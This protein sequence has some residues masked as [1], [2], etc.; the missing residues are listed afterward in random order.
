MNGRRATYHCSCT[1]NRNPTHGL[2]D[3]E[4]KSQTVYDGD[5]PQMNGVREWNGC[6]QNTLETGQ[7][8]GEREQAIHQS[9]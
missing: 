1:W 4:G 9:S 8:V 5:D 2:P 7:R 6:S 3:L